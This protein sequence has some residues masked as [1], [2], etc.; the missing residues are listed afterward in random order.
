MLK[1]ISNSEHYKEVLAHCKD[2]K[3]D[4]WIGTADI[5]DAYIDEDG[6]K[7]I[8]LRRPDKKRNNKQ[9]R[10]KYTSINLLTIKLFDAYIKYV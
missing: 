1:Y 5:K 3:H 7:A 9:A 2:I 8:V 10:Q 6:E 4:L